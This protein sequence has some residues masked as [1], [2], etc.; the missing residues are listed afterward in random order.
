[1]RT[2]SKVFDVQ[3]PERLYFRI[4]DVADL[5]GVK[6][7]V[8]RYWETEFAVIAPQKSTSGQRVYRRTDV[9][10]ILLIK[11]LLYEERYS[12]DGARRKIRE[13]KRE[14]RLRTY[15][16][17]QSAGAPTRA[18]TWSLG[19]EDE[20][21]VVFESRPAASLGAPRIERAAVEA[22]ALM[23]TVAVA[24]TITETE[25]ETAAESVPVPALET[26]SAS[27]AEDDVDFES[28]FSSEREI[29]ESVHE[30]VCLAA[31]RALGPLGEG[32]VFGE[33]TGATAAGAAIPVETARRVVA[34]LRKERL[35][36][37]IE[38][39]QDLRELADTPIQQL[40]PSAPPPASP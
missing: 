39:A 9:E 21:P 27:A 14:G 31:E 3:I 37:I 40:Y 25:T 7:Y 22:A 23:P 1:M 6:P 4:G 36:D 16:E 5:V 30:L 29:R 24:T 10:T 38:A 15:I 17:S 32:D 13:L 12:I 19:E 20:T 34:G 35:G 18:A 2:S 28:L 26:F 11:H 33:G 8:L